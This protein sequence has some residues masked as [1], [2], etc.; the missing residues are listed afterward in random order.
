MICRRLLLLAIVVWVAAGSL[1]A[2][3]MPATMPPVSGNAMFERLKTLV[4]NWQGK[5]QHGNVVHLTSS[6]FPAAAS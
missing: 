3:T 5:D 2:Q 6:S 1:P 4:G